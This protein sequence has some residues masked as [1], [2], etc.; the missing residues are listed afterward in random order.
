MVGKATNSS[1]G[2]YAINAR[3]FTLRDYQHAAKV[4]LS[5]PGYIMAPKV[6]FL[7][8]VVFNFNPPG[9]SILGGAVNKSITSLC[10]TAELP[11]FNL[12]FETL[13]KYNKKEVV[14]KKLQYEPVT[15]TFHDDVKNTIRDLW[16]VYNQYYIADSK[17]TKE[18]WATDDT[19]LNTWSFNRYG[20][21]QG[22]DVKEK[23][24]LSTVDIYSM[25]N[26]RFTKYS[27]INPLI[28]SFD[29]DR[30]DYSEGAKTMETQVRLE[31][32]S[33]LY[34]EGDTSNVTN[35]GKDS[36]YYD[37]MSS[38]LSQNASNAGRFSN[39]YGN[40]KIATGDISDYAEQ[41][42]I[43]RVRN[44]P[45]SFDNPL[46]K[47]PV[48]MDNEALKYVRSIAANA[49]NQTRS[50]SF[51]TANEVNNNLL[52][53]DAYNKRKL[54]NQGSIAS[55]GTVTSN[56]SRIS[57]VAPSS[58]GLQNTTAN[59]ISAVVVRPTVPSGLSPAEQQ[60]FLRSY[61]PL[62]STDS[63]TR[64]APYV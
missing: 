38:S 57:S 63:R 23:K 5:E 35:F 1:I 15:L 45:E 37:N 30:Y 40:Q 9:E 62:P 7:F 27:L 10:K 42:I 53:A 55:A 18:A 43:N 41:S 46:G 31:Y 44:A 20:L 60:A 21:D 61:P 29:F 4:F 32:E 51:P 52:L 48:P 13:N 36:P 50:F 12:E 14:P 59:N 17:I 58:H 19:Y 25:G 22:L 54:T 11:K 33:V 26:N 56:G 6:G 47:K 28:V 49:K 64:A 2:A 16:I 39:K 3:P 34:F 8:N 24:F